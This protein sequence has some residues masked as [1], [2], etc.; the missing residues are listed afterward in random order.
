MDSLQIRCR[1]HSAAFCDMTTYGSRPF[2]V[3][4]P[5]GVGVAGPDCRMLD[6]RIA[7][8]CGS[9][10][11]HLYARI[12]NKYEKLLRLLRRN[13]NE[14]RQGD[15]SKQQYIGGSKGGAIQNGVCASDV[16]GSPLKWHLSNSNLLPSHRNLS[17]VECG[18]SHMECLQSALTLPKADC[19]LKNRVEVPF[20]YHSSPNYLIAQGVQPPHSS[21]C[22]RHCT[23]PVQVVSK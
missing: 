5:A 19:F 13:W 6:M 3:G 22:R 20:M 7:G 8:R 1:L 4:A 12:V 18:S 17:T 16:P 15:G 2:A 14:M 10:L 23:H 21:L 9:N 11:A